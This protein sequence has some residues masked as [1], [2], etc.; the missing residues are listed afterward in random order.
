METTK[1][2][3][4]QVEITKDE[5]TESKTTIYERGF[6]EEQLKNILAQKEQQ[7]ADRDREIA[8]C[9]AILAAM[10]KAGVKLSPT[11]PLPVDEKI[12]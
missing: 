5:I 2:S 9:E 12:V 6:I 11:K 8:E 10:D 3:D 4:T 1:I 7:I